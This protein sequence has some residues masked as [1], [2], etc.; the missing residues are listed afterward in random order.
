MVIGIGSRAGWWEQN[1][2]N[3][4]VIRPFFRKLRERFPDANIETTLQFFSD[5]PDEFGIK[6]IDPVEITELPDNPGKKYVDAD[7]ESKIGKIIDSVSD[8]LG[9]AHPDTL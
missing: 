5:L 6:N 7:I 1:V 2:G 8:N 3:V 9:S 4:A